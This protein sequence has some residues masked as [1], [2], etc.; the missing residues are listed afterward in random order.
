MV[1]LLSFFQLSL[2]VGQ[3]SVD[4][5]WNK[6][7]GGSLEEQATS[8]WQTLDGGYIVS[9]DTHSDN[10]DIS[11]GNNGS[12]DY[13]IVKL[14]NLGNKEWDKTFG[15]SREER[16]QS[17]QQT[18]DGGYIVVGFTG[19]KDGDISDGNY[20]SLGSHD[21][22]IIKLDGSG[23]KVWDKTYGGSSSD[24]PCSFQQTSDGGYIVAGSTSSNNGDV[25]DG[26]NGKEDYWIIKLDGSGNKVW[27]KTLG[28]SDSDMARSIQQT[29]DDG[30]IIAG[31]TRSKD[32]DIS[33]GNYASLG[34][35]D[36]WIVKLDESGNKVWDKIYGGSWLDIANSIQ[37]TSGG[38]YIVSGHTWSND[39]D[40]SDGR[41]E[42]DENLNAW[43]GYEL[44]ILKLDSIG[45]KLWDKTLG[46]SSGDDA[47]S[48]IQ[49][50]DGGYI[51]AG[52]SRSNDGDISD[53]NN[54]SEDYWIVKLDAT[55]NKVWD[56]T[57]GGASEDYA[58]SIVQ[59]SNGGYIVAGTTFSN[60]GDV[61]DENNGNSDIWI[62]KLSE[63]NTQSLNSTEQLHNFSISPNPTTSQIVIGTDLIQT[64]EEVLITDMTG[65]IVKQF[66]IQ[67]TITKIDVSNLQNGIYMV[68][69]G[70]FTQKLIKK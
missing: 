3:Q 20:A 6:T 11:D 50:S 53:G 40:I 31:F 68:K 21:Y 35:Y 49:T 43:D 12:A 13:W 70:N 19:S 47:Y 36:Y 56:K 44:W 38:G 65:K 28:G 42:G 4:I 14:D 15:G 10:G 29:S 25:S 64:M 39:G 23:N 60:N 9:G 67:N 61:N 22:W 27:D 33:D 18:S 46:G 30:Y 54:G 59:T 32:G 69:S 37:E 2:V 66:E 8:I 57:L 24:S 55:G 58:S 1:F 7:L 51:V 63:E 52:Y 34:S 48:I 62:V 26:N 45:N 5:E 41:F 16:A 17:I